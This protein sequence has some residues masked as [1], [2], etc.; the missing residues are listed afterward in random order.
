[1]TFSGIVSA[2]RVM[3]TAAPI[4]AAPFKSQHQVRVS[5]IWESLMSHSFGPLVL[6]LRSRRAVR[7]S[8]GLDDDAC[9]SR[10]PIAVTRLDVVM[11]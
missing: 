8:N 6:V 3:N 4:D 11:T 1:M 9:A 7:P 2:S 10:D 5:L